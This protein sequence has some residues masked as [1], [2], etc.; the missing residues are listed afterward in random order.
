MSL[1]L[2]PV[3]KTELSY[4]GYTVKINGHEVP[5]DCAR[6]SAIPF[7]RRWPGH[8]RPLSQT[9]LVNFLSLSADEP[10]FFEI[11]PKEPFESVKIRPYSLGITP[12]IKDGTISFTLPKAAYFTVEP[13]GRNNALHIFTDPAPSY[14]IDKT[15]SKVIYFGKGIH[16][17]GQ[18]ELHSGETLFL[19]EGAVVYACITA[20]DTDNIKILGRG[21]LDNAHNKE[22]IHF[23]VTET[24]NSQDVGNA[25]RQHTIELQ[26]CD[27]V[28]IE[29]ITVRH[30]LVYNIRP[31][32]CKNLKI[33]N[34]K[35]IGCWRYNSDGIDMHNC[36]NVRIDNCFIRTFDDAICVKGFDFYGNIE[37]IDKA[38]FDAIHHRG[39]VYDNF[40]DVRVTNC[41]TWN[42]WGKALEIGAET[43]AEEIYDIIFQD[44]D[45]IHACS[46]LLDCC[47]VDYADAHNITWRNINIELDDNMPTPQY[48]Y[49]SATEFDNTPQGF[50]PNIIACDVLFHEEYSSGGTRR[51]KNRNLLFE[52]INIIGNIKPNFHFSAVSDKACCE[53]ITVKNVTLNGK[54]LTQNDYT[55]DKDE[56]CKN[57]KIEII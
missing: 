51:G 20:H 25:T 24:A 52:N 32:G 3:A 13:Y 1:K 48:Q 47:N 15:D 31:I 43:K 14:N 36:E 49:T 42:D 6:V 41:V 26:Y 12:E 16:E 23:A 30:S 57:I 37:N 45:C 5:L 54:P 21:I 7:N 17:V 33:N 39:R 40:F 27:N 50:A 10:L 34:V 44:C 11:T 19:D 9:E 56:F 2:Y 55:I 18:I 28:E 38:T 8:Q 4:K 29:G 46:N 35:I 53:N 22:Q